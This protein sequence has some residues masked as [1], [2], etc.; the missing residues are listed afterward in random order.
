MVSP[1]SAICHVKQLKDIHHDDLPSLCRD[2]PFLSQL[3]QG[4]QYV[5]PCRA[6]QA[7]KIITRN[8]DLN[9][10]AGLKIKFI[11][12]YKDDKLNRQQ[13]ADWMVGK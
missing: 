3:S 5:F 10:N 2:D 4:P 8:V 6:D 7:G 11:F 1:G 9:R 12:L 13:L